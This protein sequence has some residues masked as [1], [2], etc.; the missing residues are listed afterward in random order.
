M[1][2]AKALDIPSDRQC[3][4]PFELY[5]LQNDPYEQQD[6]ANDPIHQETRDELIRSLRKWMEDTADPLLAGPMAQGAYRQRMA[7]FKRI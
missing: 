6:L 4:P 2:V 5:D 1:E 3:H 7:D